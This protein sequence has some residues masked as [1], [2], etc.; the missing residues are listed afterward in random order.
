MKKIKFPN[1][2]ELGLSV[3]N[4]LWE[5]DFKSIDEF[6]AYKNSLIINKLYEWNQKRKTI[7]AE[8]FKEYC[9]Y[10]FKI[11]FENYQ[12]EK[13]VKTLIEKNSSLMVRVSND[14]EDAVKGV[15]L[16]AYNENELYFIQVKP[17]AN[18][19]NIWDTKT[20]VEYSKERKAKAICLYLENG[21][22]IMKR[23]G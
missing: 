17:N 14:W 12:R 21:K 15:D 19:L 16:V 13:Q 9:D 8:Q 18:A 20:F 23:P 3:K 10:V 1:L 22:W 6:K 5:N 4:I 7:Q 11:W 2:N